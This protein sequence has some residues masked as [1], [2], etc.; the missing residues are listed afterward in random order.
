MT[1]V[2]STEIELSE[3]INLLETKISQLEKHLRT[4]Q[5]QPV[6]SVAPP[7]DAKTVDEIINSARESAHEAV[8]QAARK[9]VEVAAVEQ[10][11]TTLK[12]RLRIAEEAKAK[13]KRDAGFEDLKLRAKKFNALV[14]EAVEV[15]EEMKKISRE[16]S[17][18]EYNP[19]VITGD[20]N[21]LLYCSIS[22]PI[23][24]VRRRPDVIRDRGYS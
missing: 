17:T 1:T 9:E 8:Q 24:R 16:T 18:R 13:L 7:E 5:S 22:D 2:E 23:I 20:P 6:L 4:L 19:F 3:E 12:A 14:D 21:E 10:A 15:L 11:L